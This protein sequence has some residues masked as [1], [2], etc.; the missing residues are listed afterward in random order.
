MPCPRGRGPGLSARP[1]YVPGQR[2]S[3]STPSCGAWPWCPRRQRP[4]SADRAASEGR[5][6]PERGPAVA[7]NCPGRLSSESSVRTR[8][9]HRL[10]VSPGPCE[11]STWR[12]RQYGTW[13]ECRR[14][15]A[16]PTPGKTP[17]V[18]VSSCSG[19]RSERS[20]TCG[21]QAV[22]AGTAFTELAGLP[23]LMPLSAQPVHV[24]SLGRGGLLRPRCPLSDCVARER[25]G[26]G[27]TGPSFR[28]H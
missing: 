24:L 9:L 28:G 6:L 16:A 11:V 23:L 10:Q 8:R 20:P 13:P 3:A 1:R 14:R 5:E 7:P 27:R 19:R 22:L 15:L 26:R 18:C 25:T 2:S 12:P 21:R 4:P 17:V